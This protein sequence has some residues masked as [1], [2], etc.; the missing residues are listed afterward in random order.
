MAAPEHKPRMK[1]P[2]ELS[3]RRAVVL[4]QDDEASLKARTE[5]DATLQQ[6]EHPVGTGVTP[7][8]RKYRKASEHREE[9]IKGPMDRLPATFDKEQK[10][11]DG[12]NPRDHR[13]EEQPDREQVT[14]GQ[15]GNAVLGRQNILADRPKGDEKARP[16]KKQVQ[17]ALESQENI[18]I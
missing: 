14:R 13:Q 7:H 4:I 3:E 8:V 16:L 15:Q 11:T 2:G 12:L 18:N 6:P 17:E 5:D 1:P 10:A 9:Q